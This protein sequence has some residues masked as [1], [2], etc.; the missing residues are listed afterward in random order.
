MHT[1]QPKVGQLF[2]SVSKG[3][4]LEHVRAELRRDELKVNRH[5]MVY[6]DVLAT[7]VRGEPHCT[8]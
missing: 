7:K 8:A 5:D 1:P 2:A 4:P 3:S 6:E